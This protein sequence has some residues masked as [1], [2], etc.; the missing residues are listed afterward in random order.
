MATCVITIFIV[1][2]FASWTQQSTDWAQETLYQIINH[3]YRYKALVVTTNVSLSQIE[4]RIHSRLSDDQNGG[5]VRIDAPDY[6]LGASNDVMTDAPWCTTINPQ[7]LFS[8]FTLQQNEL[9]TK[10]D[11]KSI[12][13][14]VHMAKVF[15]AHPKGTLVVGG[16]TYSG[17]THLGSSIAHELRTN[18]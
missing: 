16:E 7:M 10:E 8:T 14:A 15:A 1:E 11:K 5:I 12:T 13:N 3:R 6:R 9:L 4:G 17:K 18:G 2:D